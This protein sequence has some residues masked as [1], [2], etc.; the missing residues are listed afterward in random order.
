MRHSAGEGEQH[1]ARCGERGLVGGRC[2]EAEDLGDGAEGDGDREQAVSGAHGEPGVYGGVPGAR[3]L[4]E[5]PSPGACAEDAGD[6][7]NQ[8]RRQEPG[9]N[10]EPCVLGGAE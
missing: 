5:R 9:L 7:E 2:G 4:P 8:Q 10:E 6:H 1:D 3:D